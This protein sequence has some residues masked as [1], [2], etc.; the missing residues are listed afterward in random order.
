MGRR[1][2]SVRHPR[3]IAVVCVQIA[4]VQVVTQIPRHTSRVRPLLPTLCRRRDASYNDATCGSLRFFSLSASISSLRVSLVI[5]FSRGLSLSE[6][7]PLAPTTYLSALFL[8]TIK[9]NSK[10]ER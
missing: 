8:F 6:A 1:G 4:Q 5:P 9:F 7:V 2:A 10:L 3:G